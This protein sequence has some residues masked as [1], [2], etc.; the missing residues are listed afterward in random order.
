[1]RAVRG[2]GALK[3]STY[4]SQHLQDR[5]FFGNLVLKGLRCCIAIAMLTAGVLGFPILA[6][7]AGAQGGPTY[8]IGPGDVLLITVWREEDLTT[9]ATVR[10]DGRIS[11]PLVEDLVAAGKTPTDLADDITK[12]LAQYVQNPLVTVAVQSGSGDPRQQ[13]RILGE[14][15]VPSTIGYRTG[16]TLLD[17]I[18]EV[19]GLTRLADGNGA[20]IVREI[21][22]S[23]QEIPVRL[24]DLVESGDSSANVAL[25]P[26][27]IIV[28]PEGF[29]EGEWTIEWRGNAS[30][31]FSDNIDLD[32]E[33]DRDVGF[34]T[35]IGPGFSLQGNTAR[36][37]ASVEMDIAGVFQFGGD[38]E[39]FTVD[40]NIAG[41]STTVLSPGFAFFDLSAAVS[42]QALDSRNGT[43]A[44]GES[45]ENTDLVATLTASPYI[46]H[47]LANFADVE[48]R[49]RISPV[50]V[51]SGGESDVLDHE[52]RL[53]L[54]SGSDFSTLDW[55]LTNRVGQ[56]VRSDNDDITTANTDLDL[57][58]QLVRG[59]SLLGSV[60]YEYRDGDENDENNFEGVTWR[61]GFR[62]EPSP[63]LTAEAT[64]GRRDDDDSL[65]ASLDYQ[66]GPRTSL[67]AGY[68]ESLETSQG[69]A[70][71]NLENI[72]ID[73]DTGGVDDGTGGGFDDDTGPF[74]F[75]DETRRVKI[76]RFS[77]DHAS[78]RNS[79]GL[80]GLYGNSTDGTEGDEDFY[81]AA[82][83]YGRFLTQEISLN[84]GA[85]YDRSE[86]DEDDRNDD[87]YRAN[88]G[89]NYAFTSNAQASLS[90][91]FQKRDSDAEDEDYY[92]NAVTL[93]IGVS[94]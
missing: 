93:G 46:V 12:R 68:L 47:R 33:G 42:R 26:G 3:V 89:L 49:Y 18:T 37:V 9:S 41:T 30:E 58:Y 48:W 52:G 51:D 56:Q 24:A 55:T 36:I 76:F 66:I 14:A 70:V 94:F 23:S 77:A 32:D 87:T 64:Y 60:G 90:Y 53:T 2:V 40:P 29:F 82:V 85:S 75:D 74:T 80:S 65:A 16:I 79:F 27:D 63:N 38:T 67:R 15:A 43:S 7:T 5:S 10:P 13:I 31:T 35:R 22:G 19:G 25:L 21:D 81:R 69:R 62:W 71:S 91:F 39:G 72:G 78:G 61:G 20:V 73:P 28:I 57:A 8:L 45:T 88:F 4:R 11:V 17:A 34:V 84:S 54:N 1:M 59:F 92:E 86:Y 83:N 44:G 6:T 50:L